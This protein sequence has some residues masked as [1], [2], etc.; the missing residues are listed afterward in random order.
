MNT[1]RWLLRILWL[2]DRALS[3][4]SG[5]RLAFPNASG[6]EVRTLFLRTVGRKTGQKRRNGLYFVEDGPNL[7]VV[8]SNA[9]RANDPSWWLNLQ[10]HPDTEVEVRKEV[11]TVRARQA[12]PADAKRLYQ[13]FVDAL[14]QYGDYRKR[15][16]RE[17]PVV[18]LEPR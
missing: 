14:P 9:G 1:P 16:K 6:G 17:I 3:W 12:S 10:A 4:L 8:A 15:A 5:G 11:R 13:R 2:E 7:V 18:I